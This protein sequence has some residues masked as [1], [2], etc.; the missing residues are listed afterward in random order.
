MV[1][2]NQE[3]E[4]ND[5]KNIDILIEDYL[6]YDIYINNSLFIIPKLDKYFYDN[7]ARNSKQ[8]FENFNLL[9]K[10]IQLNICIEQLGNENK[11]KIEEND[12]NLIPIELFVPAFSYLRKLIYD[13]YCNEDPN[14]FPNNF[15][16]SDN[17]FHFL[18]RE[19]TNECTIVNYDDCEEIDP[20]TKKVCF[21]FPFKYKER[22][23]TF[24]LVNAFLK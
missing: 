11:I 23:S 4:N 22:W 12:F 15:Y 5:K 18:I 20:I 21:N 10:E 24:Y 2:I 9:N 13:Q 7:I 16:V 6:I 3:E 1:I 8:V 14:K 17:V 19:E